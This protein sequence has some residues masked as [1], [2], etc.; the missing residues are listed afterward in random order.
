MW[1]ASKWRARLAVRYRWMTAACDGGERLPG[2]DLHALGVRAS[3]L[4][5]ARFAATPPSITPLS[6]PL[7]AV[8]IRTVKEARYDRERDKADEDLD[9]E[10]IAA[11]VVHA[12]AH[13]RR[14]A[15]LTERETR[16]QEA[17]AA[18]ERPQADIAAD[19]VGEETDREDNLL[20]G[21]P[22]YRR[23]RGSTP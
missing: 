19:H 16:Q 13:Q 1:A 9:S 10:I 22:L 4:E 6:A 5:R 21:A 2:E 3:S 18:G 15:A 14:T 8:G 7:D 17:N 11:V 12:I 23:C 20:Q